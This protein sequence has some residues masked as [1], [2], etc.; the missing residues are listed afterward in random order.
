M[1]RL[2]TIVSFDP[3]IVLLQQA[4]PP[5]RR[6]SARFKHARPKTVHHLDIAHK[7][8]LALI[9]LSG[10]SGTDLHAFPVPGCGVHMLRA[11]H[12]SFCDFLN[13]IVDTT[14]WLPGRVI[15]AESFCVADPPNV[16]ADTSR[17]GI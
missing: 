8:K 17:I 13:D 5:K 9:N 1:L 6:L 15:P 10:S 7:F 12:Q 11:R 3:V 14:L 2:L 16:V 4:L